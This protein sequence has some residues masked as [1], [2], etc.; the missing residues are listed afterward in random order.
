VREAM[1]DAVAVQGL[2]AICPIDPYSGEPTVWRPSRHA[3][4]PEPE[5]HTLELRYHS[6]EYHTHMMRTVDGAR[7]L[8]ETDETDLQRLEQWFKTTPGWFVL[9][10]GPGGRFSSS[11][12]PT[13]EA[14]II[15][16]LSIPALLWRQ[17]QKKEG[18]L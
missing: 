16:A 10:S 2:E 12:Y 1:D 11:H 18:L 14:A 7:R 17:Q 6:Q 8:G 15:G 9:V 5:M 4:Q 3:M 13:L